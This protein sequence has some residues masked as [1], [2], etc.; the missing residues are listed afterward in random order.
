MRLSRPFIGL[1]SAA[2]ALTLAFAA[3]NPDTTAPGKQ[4]VPALTAPE[5]Q[6]IGLEAAGEV[7]SVASSFT[8]GDLFGSAFDPAFAS[9]ATAPTGMCPSISPFPPVDSESDRLPSAVI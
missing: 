9:P 8:V 7:Q 4:Q 5:A 3:C 2:S 6:S 1:A